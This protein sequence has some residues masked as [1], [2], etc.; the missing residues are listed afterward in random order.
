MERYLEY[1]RHVKREAG[2]EVKGG[3]QFFDRRLCFQAS[4]NYF[5]C[6][7]AQGKELSE[8]NKFECLNELYSFETYCPGDFVYLRRN[9][10]RQSFND[11]QNWN[12]DNLAYL[13]WKS[14]NASRRNSL[15]L[16]KPR[17]IEYLN[18]LK[19]SKL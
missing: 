1:R 6:I 13:N 2:L 12:E 3:H 5:Q 7:G 8:V 19:V 10:F 16:V 14:N 17:D 4:D 9:R 18:N 15:N 11:R